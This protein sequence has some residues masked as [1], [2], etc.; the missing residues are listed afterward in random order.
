MRDWTRRLAKW[1]GR[2][3][4]SLVLLAV[5]L[6]ALVYVPAVQDWLVRTVA[7]YAS[8][9][10]GMDVSVGRVRLAFPLDLAIHDVLATQENDSIEGQVDTIA[11]V[12]ELVASVRLLP[13]L[14]GEVEVDALDLS[15][16]KVNTAGIIH[17]CR[18]KGTLGRFSLNSHGIDLGAGTVLVQ[19]ALL[20]DAMVSVE[21]SDTVPPDTT[22]EEGAAMWRIMVERLDIEGTGV[23]IHMP[24]D[25]VAIGA[26]LAKAR[27]LDACADLGKGEYSVASI[28]IGD[29]GA[30]YDSNFEEP[31]GGF[32]FNH[33]QVT[34]LALGVDSARYSDG[35]ILATLRNCSFREKSGLE[36]ED[37]TA[38]FSLDSVRMSV[39]D[40]CLRTSESLVRVDVDMDLSAFD[41]TDPGTV[42]LSASCSIGKQDAML[43]LYGMPQPFVRGYPN[44]QLEIRAV[45]EGN[46]RYANIAAMNARLPSAFDVNLRGSAA[47]F[48]DLDSLRADISLDAKTYD[49][50]FVAAMLDL[51]SSGIAIPPGIALDGHLTA[52]GSRYA[53]DLD[54]AEGGG[55]VRGRVE[56][57]ASAMAYAADIAVSGLRIDHFVP[58]L[59]AGPLSCKASARGK[60]T[61]ILSSRTSIAA[62]LDVTEF[63]YGEYGLDNIGLE[64]NVGQGRVTASL[65]SGND[66]LTG[67]VDLYAYVRDRVLKSSVVADIGDVDFQRL[68]VSDVPLS[69]S[70]CCHVD[71]ET[72]LRTMVS[73]EGA[74]SDLVIE[75]SLRSFRPDELCFDAVASKD[76]THFNLSC[77][78][79]RLGISA[80]GALSGIIEDSGLL[81]D[82]IMGDLRQRKISVATMRRHMPMAELFV[83]T[84]ENN[85]LSRFLQTSGMTFNS[86]SLDMSASPELGLN[87]AA[88]V[89]GLETGGFKIDTIAFNIVSDS[90]KCSYNGQV[91]NGPGHPQYVFNALFDGSLLD[92]GVDFNA[93][94]YDSEDSL[95]VMVGFAATMEEKGLMVRLQPE[96]P[97]LA[98]R[99]FNVNEG[100]YLF[101]GDDSRIAAD[102]SVRADDGMGIS[103][104][105]NDE[106]ALALQD[107]TVSLDRIDL[108]SLLAAIPY[109]PDITGTLDGDVRVILTPE[110][111]T[112]ASTLAIDEMT[113][114]AWRMG[115]MGLEFVYIPK[116]DGTH[117]I[118]GLLSCDGSDVALV[119]GAYN[120][121]DGDR[122]DASLSMTRF[123][124]RLANGFI[125]DHIIYLLGYGNGEVGISGSLSSPQVEGELRLDSCY[126][127]SAQYGVTMRLD[128]GPIIIR[129]SRIILDKFN[130]YASNDSPVTLDGNIDFSDLDNMTMDMGVN[131]TNVQ[132]IDA[133]ENRYSVVYGKA[134][135][136]IYATLSG[137]VDNLTMQG[138]VDVLGNSNVS[139][140]LRDSPL[141]TD[142]QMDEL[143]RFVNFED[144]T[145]TVVT[146]EPLSGFNMDLTANVVQGVRVMC[147]LNTD[148]SNYLDIMG[149]GTLRMKYDDEGEINLVG[150]FTLDEGEMKYSLPIIPLKTF[151]IQDGSYIEFTGNPMNP[152]LNITAT[153]RVSSNV[154]SGGAERTV[155]FDCGV[156]ITRTLEDLGLE[157]TLDAPE[158][159]TLHSELMEMGLEQRGKLAVT[160]LTTGMYLADGSSGGLSVNSALNSFLQSEINNLT[161]NALRSLDLS[162]GFDNSTDASGDT[163]TDYSFKFSKRLL[164]NRLRIVVGGKVS[165]GSDA[166]DQNDSF[167]DNLTLE[168]R[169][170]NT[171]DKYLKVF[172]DN[173]AYDWLEGPTRDYGVGFTWRRTL[174]H[175]KDVFKF[176]NTDSL[177]PPKEAAT[178]KEEDED[179]QDGE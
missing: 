110:D 162:I 173:N 178:T 80:R 107:L 73:A 86:L 164:N 128:E 74:I 28:D 115:D 20:K 165:T 166:T 154:S 72:D 21:L 143:V 176:R 30:S 5:I 12:R 83:E 71:V 156:V 65:T 14:R 17:E 132:A 141:T 99:E 101:L 153:E 24:G 119:R 23:E 8:G 9:E 18:V 168:Y 36:V 63:R 159:M 42:R 46:A 68:G 123:P 67:R 98:Y 38:H 148:K 170:G 152:G 140:I 53:A 29:G 32:D 54:I 104:T 149:G 57:D 4:A 87:G 45:L 69:T 25:T 102:L 103:I 26:Y 59:D 6:A 179:A 1:V 2:G 50:G 138:R 33:I 169:L 96:R 94:F 22:A 41:D 134:F 48:M 174:Q 79:F 171:S 7:A 49:L 124:M 177:A 19:E 117:D 15:G 131:G 116:A 11:D 16:A 109:M 118:D 89:Y 100:N 85:P 113:Y 129:D 55:S 146:H 150:R 70:L 130:M 66:L 93:R 81:V 88:R 40:L 10:M 147:Y 64:A 77:G 155:D 120:P 136:D 175:F 3:I 160:M 157:F 126:L 163:H 95:G 139:Y 122:I 112:V 111:L 144:S 43:F 145:A 35:G 75:D 121:G 158:D 172:Y 92:N 97:I 90:A 51:G 151:T 13:L 60:G 27:V 114:D 167:F 133:K 44:E 52:N 34:G 125:P 82:D 78:D 47:G 58:G 108:G 76:T 31:T 62:G 137:R 105:S 39:P 127:G 106:N 135:V 142:N 37:V 91:R 56:L 161:G 84:G 61:D